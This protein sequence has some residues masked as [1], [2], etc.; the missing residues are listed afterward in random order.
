MPWAAASNHTTCEAV[1]RSSIGSR[2]EDGQ[3]ARPVDGHHRIGAVPEAA[4]VDQRDPRP[5]TEDAG[6][7]PDP[8]ETEART[9]HDHENR[10]G[11]IARAVAS[12]A[13][14]SCAAWASASRCRRLR[15]CGR[16]RLLAAA[17]GPAGWPRPPPARRS[18]GVRLLPQ[19]CHS[20]R[21][22]GRPARGPIS[23]SSRP[24]SR[25]SRS[26]HRSR[27]S[28]ASN[29]KTA[30]GGP[31]G[32]GDHA[33]GNGTF[34]TGVRLKKSATDIRAGVSIDQ[35]IAR[36]DRPPHA[37]PVAGAGAATAVRK[38][39]ACDSGYSCAYQFNLSWS[40]PTT[41]MPPETNPRLVFERLFG[42]GAPGERQA[43][44]ERRRQ[45][46]RSLLDFVLDDARSMQ[47]DSA[48]RTEES[49]TST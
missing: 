16:P 17:Q 5:S 43:N 8:T 10:L 21:R 18:H 42:A 31:D 12:A 2:R 26:R 20:Q 30:D 29:H 7:A 24:S 34:L 15:R 4:P 1:D 25:S 41:P 49:S 28:A 38:A 13:G 27:S 36:Q 48:P 44:L 46:Q 11:R 22:G 47:R 6:Q 23:S 37:V 19:R 35:V 45:E 9:D 14:T 33:R 3:R 39:G 32:A 40:S